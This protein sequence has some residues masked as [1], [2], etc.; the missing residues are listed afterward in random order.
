MAS[1]TWGSVSGL[2]KHGPDAEI[3]E[4]GYGREETIEGSVM[5]EFIFMFK[6]R[7]V[8]FFKIEM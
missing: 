2:K 1:W 5:V 8:L 6:E 7:G 4:A 3:Y